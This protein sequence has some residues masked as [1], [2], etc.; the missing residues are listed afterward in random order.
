MTRSDRHLTLHRHGECQP[1]V[2]AYVSLLIATAAL[3]LYLPGLGRPALWEPDEGRYAEI[4]R[5]MYLSGD[6]VTPRD[7]FVRYFEKPPLVYWCRGCGDK[8]FRY[9]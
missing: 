9:K 7:D 8:D 1:T 2:S 4:A 3:I 6:Y 5:E